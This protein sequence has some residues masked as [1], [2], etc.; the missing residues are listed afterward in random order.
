MNV[1][2]YMVCQ[3]VESH[4]VKVPESRLA[5]C[6][7]WWSKAHMI[8]HKVQ[9]PQG[10]TSLDLDMLCSAILLYIGW[11]TVLRLPGPLFC[12]FLNHPAK[13]DDGDDEPSNMRQFNMLNAFPNLKIPHKQRFVW[14]LCSNDRRHPGGRAGAGSTH[15]FFVCVG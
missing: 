10:Q 6:S 2:R 8:S 14:H 1:C 9:F 5:D 7:N 11:N 4:F 15:P 3:N 12:H 13:D